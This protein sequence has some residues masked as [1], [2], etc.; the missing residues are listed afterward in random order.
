MSLEDKLESLEKAVVALTDVMGQ[1]VEGQARNLEAIQSMS[2]AA[3][4][5][6]AKATKAT[7]S[8]KEAAPAKE[9][10]AE[11]PYAGEDGFAKLGGIAREYINGGGEDQV[12]HRKS[13]IAAF[14]KKHGAENFGGLPEDKRPEMAKYLEDLTA[15]AE[16]EAKKS[17]DIGI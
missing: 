15:Q 10:E 7:K 3:A 16:A 9:P 5:K 12:E 14:F 13:Q 17:A 1:V 2:S 6:P 11:N 8:T 4:A